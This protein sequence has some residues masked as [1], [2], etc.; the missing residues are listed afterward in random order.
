VQISAE[1]KALIR[2]LIA[3]HPDFPTKGVLFRDIQPLLAHGEAYGRVIDLM[4]QWSGKPEAFVGIESRGF[5]FSAALAQAGKTGKIMLRKA[6]KIP[7]KVE[8]E[9]YA[10]EYGTATIEVGAG[11]V[12]PGASYVVVDDVLATGGT[13]RAACTLV[14]RLGGKVAG[15][16]FVVEIEALKGRDPLIDYKVASLIKY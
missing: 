8:A 2:N 16:V 14:E 7:G 1:D 9:S 13:A 5:I 10:L 3:D 4:L 11:I 6:G 12:R 15:C